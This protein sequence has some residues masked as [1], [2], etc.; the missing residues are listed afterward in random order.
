MKSWRGRKRLN[1]SDQSFYGVSLQEVNRNR[2]GPMLNK[3]RVWLGLDNNAR[4]F[5]GALPS[6][7][8]QQLNMGLRTRESGIKKKNQVFKASDWALHSSRSLAALAPGAGY[9]FGRAASGYPSR[10]RDG[11]RWFACPVL[12]ERRRGYHDAT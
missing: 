1:G 3:Q 9:A 8:P 5:L 7:T 11:T 4:I 6:H 2:L 10:N 12:L